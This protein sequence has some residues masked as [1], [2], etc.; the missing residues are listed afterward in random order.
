MAAQPNIRT[1]KPRKLLPPSS[2]GSSIN[3][4]HTNSRGTGGSRSH[5]T[6]LRL[7]DS[8]L[9][10]SLSSSCINNNIPTID[11]TQDDNGDAF[12]QESF[13]KCPHGSLV[14]AANLSLVTQISFENLLQSTELI[15]ELNSLDSSVSTGNV[16]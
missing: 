15:N 4:S 7:D 12:H 3:F 13:Q 5:D 1:P 11:L 8:L 16:S 9:N 2:S 14:F 6:N 10:I